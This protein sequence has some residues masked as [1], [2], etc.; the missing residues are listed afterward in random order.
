MRPPFLHSEDWSARVL[1]LE[2]L[3]TAAMWVRRRTCL[4]WLELIGGSV[5]T[6]CCVAVRFQRRCQITEE[7]TQYAGSA[8]NN[9]RHDKDARV[10]RLRC[11]MDFNWSD[12]ETSGRLPA[13]RASESWQKASRSVVGLSASFVHDHRNP[14]AT[15]IARAEML[16]QLDPAPTQVKRVAANI[17][18][19]AG[20]MRELLAD[21]AGASS[22]NKST[23]EI[24]RIRDVITAASEAA[25][26]AG[27][28]QGVQILHDVP[29]ALEIPLER[30]RIERVFFRPDYKCC[31][32]DASRREGPHWRE[33][34]GQLR[35]DRSRRLGARNSAWHSRPVVR[36]VRY[37]QVG[38][39]LGT[40]G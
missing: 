14:L 26:P 13:L 35:A 23:C 2:L 31:R 22:G 24:C 10:A 9:Q 18:R 29:D 21:L 19:A 25:L 5:P 34:G 40:S 38:P 33:E 28:T 16:M 27:Q 36:A 7:S 32:S 17:Y 1:R 11:H 3:K 30:S 15:V 8:R 4:T 37:L 12:R 20:R 6:A 39:R